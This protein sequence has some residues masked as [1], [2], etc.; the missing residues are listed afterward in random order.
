[1]PIPER[2]KKL[3]AALSL[4]QRDQWRLL[5]HFAP[6]ERHQHDRCSAK[7]NGGEAPQAEVFK[8]GRFCIQA[9]INTIFI[10]PPQPFLKLDDILRYV[11]ACFYDA[12]IGEKLEQGGA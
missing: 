10:I 11:H 7:Q 12:L 9:D 5:R 1:M 3:A 8:P 2:V 4:S 6:H